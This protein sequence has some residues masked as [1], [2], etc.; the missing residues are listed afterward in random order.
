M[1]P[2]TS[3]KRLT[4]KILPPNRGVRSRQDLAIELVRLEH[5]RARLSQSINHCFSRIEMEKGD[6]TVIDNRIRQ[7]TGHLVHL[8]NT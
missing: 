8:K 2:Y 6:L 7:I 3:R 1:T 5:E 4:R